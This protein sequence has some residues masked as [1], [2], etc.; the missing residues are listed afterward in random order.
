MSGTD[1]DWLHWAKVDPYF[2][3]VTHDKF[4]G[5][6]NK[7]E[8][9][10]TGEASIAGIIARLESAF[11]PLDYRRALEFGCG[12]G[13]LTVPLARRFAAVSAVDISSDMLAEAKA[14]CDAAGVD[15]EFVLSDDRLTRTGSDFDL[16][17]S[18]IT[19]QHI[20]RERGLVIIET[21]LTRLAPRGAIYLDVPIFNP[22]GPLLRALGYYRRRL[23]HTL[24]LTP[25]PI[26]MN[27]YPFD[28][29]VQLFHRFGI[30]TTTVSYADH[31][32]G[33]V[34]AGVGGRKETG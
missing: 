13:R 29:I 5:G 4:R 14:N 21:M 32:G 33:I 6:A 12:V 28:A 20:P 2:A 17:L 27:V 11:G 16:I 7:V 34:V 24:G 31:G 9:L 18:L 8:F 30:D 22:R 10:A 15:A 23:T 1:A 19:L 3:V 25:P 26:Q